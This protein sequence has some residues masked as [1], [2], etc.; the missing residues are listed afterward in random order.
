M[1]VSW[2]IPHSFLFFSFF[3]RSTHLTTIRIMSRGGKKTYKIRDNNGELHKFGQNGGGGV[4]SLAVQ[5]SGTS[6]VNSL[7]VKYRAV[8]AARLLSELHAQFP[9]PDL[10]HQTNLKAQCLRET[11]TRRD[12]ANVDPLN[13]W[14][15]SINENI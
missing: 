4:G 12:P 15:R 3:N 6:A 11:L 10:R 7:V 2:N 8:T 5:P 9:P 13:R 1:I 14:M